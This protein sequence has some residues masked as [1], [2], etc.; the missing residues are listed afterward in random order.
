MVLAFVQFKKLSS[1]A[2]QGRSCF[3][4]KKVHTI[5]F[6]I[7]IPNEVVML[8]NEKMKFSNLSIK[9]ALEESSVGNLEASRRVIKII[10]YFNFQSKSHGCV[11]TS[12]FI[13]TLVF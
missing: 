6:E 7:L 5:F 1:F 12:A 3:S 10:Y 2:F 4:K 9:I 11:C 8:F 13:A